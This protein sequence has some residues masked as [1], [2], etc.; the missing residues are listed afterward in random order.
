MPARVG[1]RVLGRGDDLDRAVL[2]R[3]G[4]AEPAV[5]A[6]GGGLELGEVGCLGI[7]GMR[8]ERGQHAVDR[9]LDQRMVVDLVDIVG[10][11]P[12]EHADER[13]QLL[14]GVGVG[15]G[16]ARSSSSGP[17][18]A[19]RPAPGAEAAWASVH[20]SYVLSS[21]ARRLA[22]FRRHL[23]AE[24]MKLRLGRATQAA[25]LAQFDAERPQRPAERLAGG[26]P[27]PGLATARRR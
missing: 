24:Q 21:A 19:R 17:A 13:L 12:L 4:Q 16:E 15:G 18:P 2:G 6:V 5:I 9:A 1:R 20:G 27:G 25:H 11:H 8:V 7:A 10:A 26:D 23:T 14:V 3:N 22:A